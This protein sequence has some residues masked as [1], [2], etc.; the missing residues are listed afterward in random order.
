MPTPIVV[1]VS[2]WNTI[3]DWTALASAGIG[4]VIHKVTEGTTYVDPT[5]APRR[6]Q[7]LAAGLVWGGY[8][9]LRPGDPVAQANFFL[10]NAKP[11]SHMLLA[12][13]HEDSGVSPDNLKLFLRTI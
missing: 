5:Y 9:F 6:Q 11:D 8:H 3:T 7:A 10:A 12:A 13:D 2:H 4:G 1:D